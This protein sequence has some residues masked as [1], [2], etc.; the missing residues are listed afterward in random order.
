MPL[1]SALLAAV[2][3]VPVLASGKSGEFVSPPISVREPSL[4]EGHPLPK[5][6]INLKLFPGILQ[7]VDRKLLLEYGYVLK[8]N[9]IVL[10]DEPKLEDLAKGPLD[11]P[12]LKDVL[13]RIRAIKQR[14]VLE[15]IHELQRK[16]HPR[17]D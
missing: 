6:P 2:L 9:F 15:K 13:S 1:L 16:T 3:A 4:S 10:G 17:R 7:P 11:P 12:T 8:E 5:G 14:G